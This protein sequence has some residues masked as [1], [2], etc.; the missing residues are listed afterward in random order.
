VRADADAIGRS[1]RYSVR[2]L[3]LQA[4][5]DAKERKARDREDAQRER[6]EEQQE[7]VVPARNHGQ[8]GGAR[9]AQQVGWSS[10]LL[11]GGVIAV[12]AA[13]LNAMRV[14]LLWRRA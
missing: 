2:P 12:R 9:S 13:G 6:A 14:D 10:A 8:R 4:S 7:T 5:E 1:S 3:V 11:S